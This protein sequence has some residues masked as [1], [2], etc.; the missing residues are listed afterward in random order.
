MVLVAGV[1]WS[2]VE[3]GRQAEWFSRSSARPVALPHPPH[4][5]LSLLAPP[6]KVGLLLL[7]YWETRQME[8]YLISVTQ[9]V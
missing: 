6:H 1:G 7:V 8:L 4:R 3:V 9:L 2:V 5:S